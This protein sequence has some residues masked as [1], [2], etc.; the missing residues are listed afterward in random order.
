MFIEKLARNGNVLPTLELFHDRFNAYLEVC[1]ENAD[2]WA[3][4]NGVLKVPSKNEKSVNKL[5]L[6][7][8]EPYNTVTFEAYE[9][10][11]FAMMDIQHKVVDANSVRF[12]NDL[13]EIHNKG[14]LKRYFES[15]PKRSPKK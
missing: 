15:L 14:G 12:V 2:K 4:T 13:R 10:R 9:E 1:E 11:F 5:L 8:R 7:L 3:E 6:S